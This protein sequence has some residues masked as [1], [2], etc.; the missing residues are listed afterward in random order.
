MWRSLS[1]SIRIWLSISILVFGY[2]ISMIVG[3]FLGQQTETRLHDVSAYLVPAAKHSQLAMVKFKEQAR[4]Y[5]DAVLFGEKA[6][7]EAALGNSM[8]IQ[9]ELKT[10]IELEGVE[11]RKKSELRNIIKDHKKFTEKAQ[12]LY[13]SMSSVFE[14]N[15]YGFGSGTNFKWKKEMEN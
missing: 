11:E 2:F 3:Y 6:F 1:I 8:N 13:A 15:E 12:K 4:F 5:Q 9:K 14:N 7:V 10:I